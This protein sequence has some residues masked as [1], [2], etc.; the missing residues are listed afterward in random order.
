MSALADQP[1]QPIDWRKEISRPILSTRKELTAKPHQM[2]RL[3]RDIEHRASQSRAIEKTLDS[4]HAFTKLDLPPAAADR[5][6]RCGP[7]GYSKKN[8][9]RRWP[10]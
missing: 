8:G 4:I 6:N 7:P 1:E 5:A 3:R 10:L 9:H 2:D